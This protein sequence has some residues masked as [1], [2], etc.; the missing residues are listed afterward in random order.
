MSDEEMKNR[1]E[2]MLK[3]LEEIKEEVEDEKNEKIQSKK[4]FLYLA[5]MQNELLKEMCFNPYFLKFMSKW[6]Q[7]CIKQ[8]CEGL[9]GTIEV[10][11]WDF[12]KEIPE[13][14]YA[15]IKNEAIV[16]AHFTLTD[17]LGYKKYCGATLNKE[18]E[19]RK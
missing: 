16:D 19:K 9:N 14:E 13:E 17:L 10:I 3:E 6:E 8:N 1:I 11:E 7:E 12:L 15:K 18:Y 5:T 4:D 2:E